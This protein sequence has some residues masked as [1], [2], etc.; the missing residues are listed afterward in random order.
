M[1]WPG[2]RAMSEHDRGRHRLATELDLPHL[3]EYLADYCRGLARGS[4]DDLDG[5]LADFTSAI[6]IKPTDARYWNG[7]GVASTKKGDYT[8]AIGAFLRMESNCRPEDAN[9]TATPAGRCWLAPQELRYDDRGYGRNDPLTG[10]D[11]GLLQSGDRVS[12]G[13]A[14]SGRPSPISRRSSPW[15][16]QNRMQLLEPREGMG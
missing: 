3:G 2:S 1:R 7:R 16:L 9:G 11:V 4:R 15:T 10:Q 12:T 6:S 8:K 5:A 13:R 14:S